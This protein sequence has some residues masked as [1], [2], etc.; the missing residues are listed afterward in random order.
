MPIMPTTQPTPPTPPAP[1]SIGPDGSPAIAGSPA[2]TPGRLVATSREG[3]QA[4]KRRRDE[5]RSQMDA[6]TTRRSELV[7]ELNAATD[8]VVRNGFQQ[9][10]IQLDQRILRIESE[11]D[12]NGQS[13]AS[14]PMDIIASQSTAPRY[15]PFTSGQ[16]TAI[17]IVSIVLVWAPL[18][19]AVARVMLRRW[20][21]P[22]PAPQILES[23]ARL[24]RMEQAV[25]AVAI[26]V[27]RISEG[28]RFVT[29]L[30]SKQASAL[31]V[32]QAAAEPIRVSDAATIA[33]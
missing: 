20:A 18:A 30:M 13:I 8:P 24:E 9:R 21:V 5:L 11:I 28:Q 14:G 19:F 16:L 3:L 22:R 33:R 6:A 26:E 4:L 31:G 29:Q 27:E 32:G 10:I 12:V 2:A 1:P 15:G 17:S 23:A 25:D 7:K